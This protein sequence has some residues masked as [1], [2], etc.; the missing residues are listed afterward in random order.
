MLALGL[1]LHHS[2]PASFFFPREW[3]EKMK[4]SHA[5][6]IVLVTQM[7]LWNKLLGDDNDDD[8]DDDEDDDDDD[9]MKWQWQ[10]Q[11]QWQ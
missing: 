11:W 4:M 2:W 8:D 5:T 1:A 9:V 6:N 7:K 10:W 3:H